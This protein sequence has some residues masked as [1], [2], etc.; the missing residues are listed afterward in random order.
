M[1]FFLTFPSARRA[2]AGRADKK[3]SLQMIML[4]VIML[5]FFQQLIK[6]HEMLHADDGRYAAAAERGAR[7]MRGS[8][9]SPPLCCVPASDHDPSPH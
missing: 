2:V 7:R 1:L 4:Q 8:T 3:V 9:P 6:P 5:V